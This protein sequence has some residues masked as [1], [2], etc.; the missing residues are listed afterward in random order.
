[1]IQRLR[2]RLPAALQGRDYFLFWSAAGAESLG[3][4][5]VAVAIGWQVFSIRHSAFDLG[6]IGLLEFVPMLLLAL[7]AGQLADR[8]SRHLLFAAAIGLSAFVALALI[9]VTEGGA[10]QLWPFLVLA[11]VTGVANVLASASGRALG[12]M[13]V[14]WELLP[15]AIA[16]R[17]LAFQGGT[18]VG[19]AL[20]GL[21]FA[22]HPELVYAVATVLLVAGTAAVLFIREPKFERSGDAPSWSTFL[23]GVRFIRRTP[24]M[25]GAITLDLFAVL[26]GGAVALLPLFA[27]QILHTGPLGLGILRSA[28]AVGA[29]LAG[30]MLAHRPL[31]THT[32]TTLL[33]VVAAFGASMVVFGLSKTMW[34]SVAAL[35]VGGFV[36]MI[37]MNIRSTIAAVATPDELRGRVNAVESVFIS[38]SNELGAFE[39]GAAAALLGA[40]PAV[41]LG[42]AATIVLAAVW[43]WVFPDLANIDRIEELRPEPVGVPEAAL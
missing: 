20:G 15:S 18:I 27:K 29:L 7:P 8:V 43:K 25:L 13:L 11:A 26:F 40:V 3:M 33:T 22:I 41:V 1:L 16:L 2:R 4:N 6:L 5:M 19:P 21:L 9:A 30:L 31:R 23:A 10:D 14:P 37:S 12:V 42:G 28:T 35:A 24:V 38:A 32:G 39:S 34:L 17:S 36:D